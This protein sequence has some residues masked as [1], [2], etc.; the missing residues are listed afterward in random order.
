MTPYCFVQSHGSLS[1]CEE[2][3]LPVSQLDLDSASALLNQQLKNKFQHSRIVYLV[4]PPRKGL[5]DTR[6]QCFIELLESLDSP[7]EKIILMSTTGV[8]GDC[9]GQWIDETWPSSPQAERAHRRL[10][11]ETQLQIYCE[12]YQI[13]NIIFRVP[14]IYSADKLPKKRILSGDPIVNAADSGYSN[15][16][17]A[18]DLSA[19]CLEA[20][21]S[22]VLPGL[23]N[24][25]DGQP[26]SM[27]DYF[28]KV[29]QALDLP[30]P[31]EISL[32][33]AR[34]E[35]SPGMLSYLAES[36]RISNKK[37]LANF[38]TRLKYPNLEYGLGFIK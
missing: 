32:V 23:Y 7:P 3:N 36:K 9:K 22:D 34:R 24:C 1:A 25:C 27:N 5:I 30:R 2:L 8:Y 35:L 26:S 33:Q 16:I 19:F 11:A 21:L 18:H 17:H 37:L 28:M 6:M 4:P 31:V 10:S 13:H 15:R 29:A 38:S 20:L 14:G 12:K